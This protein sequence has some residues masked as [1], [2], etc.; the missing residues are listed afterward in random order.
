MNKIC[1]ERKTGS[2]HGV[3]VYIYIYCVY[4][5]IK[6]VG[7]TTR[8]REGDNTDRWIREKE[9]N[10]VDYR[11][12]V[13]QGGSWE[14]KEEGADIYNNILKKKKSVFKSKDGLRDA[15]CCKDVG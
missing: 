3:C 6:K 5:Y 2:Q 10:E 14:K 4:A 12:R 1:W 13:Q 15:A 7:R 11:G 8:K 9:R